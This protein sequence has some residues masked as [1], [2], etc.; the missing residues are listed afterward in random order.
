MN[1]IQ[2]RAKFKKSLIL[3][4]SV[5][6]STIVMGIMVEKLHP[7]KYAVLQWHLQDINTTTNLSVKVDFTLTALSVKN[8]VTWKCHVDD[9]AKGRYD[10]ILGRDILT[11]LVLNLKFSEHFIES[12]D[13]T[14]NR[15][16]I[17]MVD[18]GMCIFKYL[19]TGE[20]TPEVPFTND[21][22]KEVYESKNVRTATK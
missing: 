6:S 16:K 11:Q 12:D 5:C 1:T 2:G 22:V 14:L 17:P 4:D 3:F 9:S 20:I 15:S 7:V 13:G 8:I 21:N 18:L 10:M 19:N